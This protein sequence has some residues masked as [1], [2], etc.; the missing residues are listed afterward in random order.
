MPQLMGG[1][2]QNPTQPEFLALPQ[3][4]GGH[5]QSSTR[6]HPQPQLMLSGWEGEPQQP[7]T[8][9]ESWQMEVLL[10]GAP[11]QFE[12]GLSSPERGTPEQSEVLALEWAEPLPSFTSVPPGLR[13]PPLQSF[14]LPPQTI[15]S[16][17]LLNTDSPTPQWEA[18]IPS[19]G[20][21]APH[22]PT[23]CMPCSC[24]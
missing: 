9:P 19:G 2:N 3:L 15:L 1:F 13:L 14:Q 16:L 11:N 12:V 10:V 20:I 4:E 17:S 5:N 23:W 6:E 21:Q 8:P 18:Q 22:D 7:Q 24:I